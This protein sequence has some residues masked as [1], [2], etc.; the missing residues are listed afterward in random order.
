MATAE[1]VLSSFPRR[2]VGRGRISHVLFKGAVF[3]SVILLT[4]ILAWLIAQGASWAWAPILLTILYGV[5]AVLFWLESTMRFPVWLAQALGVLAEVWPPIKW[6]R[7]SQ[8][9]QSLNEGFID[10]FNRT[11][12][13]YL[14]DEFDPR[15]KEE[16]AGR[17]F[18]LSTRTLA[19]TWA[20]EHAGARKGGRPTPS[21]DALELLHHERSGRITI[22]V[23]QARGERLIDELVPL[24]RRS[25]RVP[26]PDPIHPY[27][28][29][30]V[31]A[32]LGALRDF[33][34]ELLAEELHAVNRIGGRLQ[35]YAEFLAPGG[36]SRVP[37]V[38]SLIAGQELGE[39]PAGPSTLFRLESPAETVHLMEAIEDC[40]DEAFGAVHRG[41]FLA[42]RDIDA[43]PL[44]ERACAVLF[45]PHPDGGTDPIRVLQAFLWEKDQREKGRRGGDRITLGELDSNW[46]QWSREARAGLE[47]VGAGFEADL[48]Q[49]AERLEAGIWPTR[50]ALPGTGSA[51]PPPQPTLV[52]GHEEVRDLD[53]YL[54]TFDERHG[55]LGTL[56]D[57]LKRPGSIYRFGP[58]TRNTRLGI[59]PRG[60]PFHEFVDRLLADLDDAL[61]R[62]GPG[63][64]S[65]GSADDG[66]LRFAPGR[67]RSILLK[68]D[69]ECDGPVEF[70]ISRA[71]RRC[72][73]DGEVAPGTPAEAADGQLGE[74]EPW[75]ARHDRA[76]VRYFPESV[77]KP[78]RISFSFTSA[79]PHKTTT[80]TVQLL[81]GPK[82]RESRLDQIELTVNRIDLAH[83]RELSF[84]DPVLR[85]A[86]RAPSIYD[87]WREVEPELDQDEREP[88]KAAFERFL[89]SASASAQTSPV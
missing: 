59:V 65:D 70:G 4:G 63:F 47:K 48:N 76:L 5:G 43:G 32:L 39:L 15:R 83:C 40:G 51:Y 25:P 19:A 41:I 2:F 81:V 1:R 74:I 44:K 67:P 8:E 45:E 86:M 14:L 85:P 75:P 3:L 13:E 50:R 26:A 6:L 34:L 60:M 36:A 27:T 52:S 18:P 87:V 69:H 22:H 38:T 10:D 57:G 82:G 31:H 23:W 17:I 62:Y 55:P 72:K 37:E 53:A 7:S 77:A 35:R 89:V 29:E 80:R 66:A 33:D 24:V 68:H 61:H 49:L 46:E 73:R 30:D 12:D 64:G 78:R 58:Y 71:L 54:I 56:V 9:V 11:L 20:K 42:E 16:L 21:A 79:C 28:D 88:V 84:G